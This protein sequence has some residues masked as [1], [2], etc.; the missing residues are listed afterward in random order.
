MMGR[1]ADAHVEYDGPD[2]AV[3]QVR[4]AKFGL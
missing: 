1:Q 3:T 4:E 2:D